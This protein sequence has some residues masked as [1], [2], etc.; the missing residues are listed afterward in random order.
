M[1]KL[2]YLPYKWQHRFVTI[3]CN[4]NPF[5]FFMKFCPIKM[6]AGEDFRLFSGL[7]Q[8]WWLFSCRSPDGQRMCACIYHISHLL[9]PIHMCCN[10][11]SLRNF[12]L[13]FLW[14]NIH[15]L[16][17]GCLPVACTP[18]LMNFLPNLLPCNP[19]PDCRVRPDGSRDVRTGLYG[20][21]HF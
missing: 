8:C 13:H 14:I 3:G 15:K 7:P 21:H 2:F 18:V 16:L 19:S 17:V 20:H 9:F 1:W 12:L 10:W 6:P 4:F 11:P 5:S